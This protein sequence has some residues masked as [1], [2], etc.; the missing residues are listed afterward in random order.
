LIISHYNAIDYDYYAITYYRYIDRWYFIS[1]YAITLDLL[2]TLF[3]LHYI[4]Y[5]YWL[6]LPDRYWLLTLTPL[7]PLFIILLPLLL[8]IIDTLILCF[9][10]WYTLG[11]TFH[12]TDTIITLIRWRHSAITPLIRLRYWHYYYDYADTHWY[13]LLMLILIFI[14]WYAL[15][16]HYRHWH[17]IE[18]FQ[19]SRIGIT[20]CHYYILEDIMPCYITYYYWWILYFTLLH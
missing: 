2:F 4:I 1:H 13:I 7:L 19:P 10:H 15:R 3:S 16:R 11:W 12:I 14:Y 18:Y 8:L 20:H 17:F 5:D 6:T 9:R